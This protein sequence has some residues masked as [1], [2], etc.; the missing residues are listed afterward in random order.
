MIK[1]DLW[2]TPV[3]HI[4]LPGIDPTLI[5]KEAYERRSEDPDLDPARSGGYNSSIIR[6]AMAKPET[7]RL[8]DLIVRLA[9]PIYE[10]FGYEHLPKVTGFWVNIFGTNDYTESH[11]H[12]KYTMSAVYWAQIPKNSGDLLLHNRVEND[13]IQMTWGGSRDNKYN[14]TRVRYPAVAGRLVIFPAWVTHSVERNLSTEDRISL[15]F[16]I[17]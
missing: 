6:Q 4:D 12:P 8:C 9:Q 17:S 7:K 3:W 5:T 10:D 16:N 15:A 1:T 13:Y 14:T 2:A 11:N